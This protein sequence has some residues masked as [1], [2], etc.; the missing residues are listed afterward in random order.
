MKEEGKNTK[1]GKE[2]TNKNRLQRAPRADGVGGSVRRG[3]Q[4]RQPR[5]KPRK[6]TRRKDRRRV[7]LEEQPLQPP[8][9]RLVLDGELGAL[10]AHPEGRQLHECFERQFGSVASA[11]AQGRQLR[12]GPGGEAPFLLLRPEGVPGAGPRELHH[13]APRPVRQEVLRQVRVLLLRHLQQVL[14]LY[15]R[16]RLQVRGTCYFLC[17]QLFLF[18]FFSFFFLLFVYFFVPFLGFMFCLFFFLLFFSCSAPLLRLPIIIISLFHFVSFT[19]FDSHF[20]SFSFN[21]SSI[22]FSFPFHFILHLLFFHISS[23][24]SA[25]PHD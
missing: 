18:F 22:F 2:T 8:R 24:Q 12:A 11:R 23:S 15:H 5:R 3:Q 17:C 14:P 16:L 25:F 7:F 20:P 10:H 13:E 6:R 19:S 9:P 4:Q 21:F 1:E